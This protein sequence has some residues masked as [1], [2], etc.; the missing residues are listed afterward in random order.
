MEKRRYRELEIIFKGLANHRRVQLLDTLFREPELSVMEIAE[1]LGVD[2][3]TVSEHTRKLVLGGLIMKRNEAAAVRHAL[4]IRG[5][6]ILK[7]CRT[8][9]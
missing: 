3:R 7:F 1:R 5:K 6:D 2:F 8:L 4:T 9:E